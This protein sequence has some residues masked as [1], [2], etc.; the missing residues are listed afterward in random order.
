MKDAFIIGI[1]GGSGS[2]K[3][4][5]ANRIAEHF[6]D[7]VA[8]IGCDNYYRAMDHLSPEERRKLNFDAPEA[9]E[10]DLMVRHIRAL[11]A[12][13]CVEIPVYDFVTHTRRAETAPICPKPVIIVDGIL[14]F[15]HPELR[16]S[17]DL[18]IYVDTDADL[19]IL[20][21][22]A[23]D[24]E[25]RGRT[26]TDVMA[27]YIAT[28]KPMHEKYVEPTK[29]YADIIVNGG[30]NEAALDIVKA[31]ISHILAKN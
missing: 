21:R 8:L 17:F 19:R 5:F 6:R 4:T 3:S 7:D 14:I 26:L 20:R 9:L 16:D 10:L 27:Q 23:R 29:R 28:V 30:M 15:S 12:G 11:K 2:G 24:I 25:S 1:A 31:K 18:K 13:Q 22:A